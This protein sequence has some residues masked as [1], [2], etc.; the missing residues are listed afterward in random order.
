MGNNKRSRTAVGRAVLVLAI[1]LFILPVYAQE[2]VVPGNPRGLDHKFSELA[3]R[4]PGFGGM[5]YD[6]D[7][8]LNVYLVDT[9]KGD[10]VRAAIPSVFAD[11]PIRADKLKIVPARYSFVQLQRWYDRL[12]AQQI[13]AVPGVVTTDLDE[14][15]NRLSIGVVDDKA[16][17]RVRAELRA[18]GDIPDDAF[19]VEKVQRVR[20][21]ATLRELIRP[22]L[23]GLQIHLANKFCTL[24]FNAIGPGGVRGFVTNSHCTSIQ[25]GV[26]NTVFYQPNVPDS[27]GLEVSDPLYF[28]GYPCPG[29]RVC[30]WSDSAFAAYDAGIANTIGVV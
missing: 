20:P 8:T 29:G 12:Q 23:G 1:F 30:R 10:E 17:E 4:V 24:G 5:F 2:R 25:G 11:K 26:E 19:I 14:K 22:V 9:T 3:K 6:D 18:L 21:A 13:L 28:A 7:G 15:R 27:I 16:G